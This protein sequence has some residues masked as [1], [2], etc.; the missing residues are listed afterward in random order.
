[1]IGGGL[2]RLY[3]HYMQPTRFAVVKTDSQNLYKP[4]TRFAVSKTDTPNFYKDFGTLKQ[5]FEPLQTSNTLNGNQNGLSNLK[6]ALNTLC[7]SQNG[8]YELLHASYT[9]CG[10]QIG[11]SEPLRRPLHAFLYSKQTL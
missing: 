10:S 7:G 9:F 2:N 3:E 11:H 5:L 4:P 8:G 6:R 1:M